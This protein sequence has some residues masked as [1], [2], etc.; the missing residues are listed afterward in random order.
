MTSWKIRIPA[1]ESI[2]VG[3]PIKEKTKNKKP[4]YIAMHT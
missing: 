1:T 4:E 3:A 2:R